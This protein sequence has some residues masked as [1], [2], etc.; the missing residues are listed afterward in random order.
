MS[1]R[2]RCLGVALLAAGLI[3]PRPALPHAALIE[4]EAAPAIRLHAFY[5]TGGPMAGAQVIVFAP[6]NPSE[7]W[8]RG[9]TD[10]EGRFVFFPG[11]EAGRW[12][13]QVRQAGHG[14]MAHVEIDGTTPALIASAT[15]PGWLE[16]AAMIGLVAWGALGTALFA[17]RHRGR[18][19]ASS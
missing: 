10:A 8:D 9:T 15:A 5:D 19:D 17:I 4:A 18:R 16:R 2:S 6:G 14:A 7:A 1:P 13:V 3:A 11:P 12:T